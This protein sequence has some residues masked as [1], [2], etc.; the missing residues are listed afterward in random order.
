MSGVVEY[1]NLLQMYHWVCSRKNFENRLTFGEVMGKRLVCCFLTHGA[2]SWA[3]VLH[4]PWTKQGLDH[5]AK[6]PRLYKTAMLGLGRGPGGCG[7]PW[8]F[9]GFTDR[10]SRHSRIMRISRIG[11]TMITAA[12]SN[13]NRE[14]STYI[15]IIAAETTW[16]NLFH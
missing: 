10:R 3:T 13:C 14:G 15:Y 1:F 8:L 11:M 5:K 7:L 9:Y 12:S 6:S 2:V 16:H 4:Q